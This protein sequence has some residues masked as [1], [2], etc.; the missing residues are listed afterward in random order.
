[1]HATV[2]VPSVAVLNAELNPV[3]ATVKD[4]KVT[5]QPV[6]VG[7][8]NGTRTQILSGLRRGQRVA[9]TNLQDLSNGSQ[10]SV[11]SGGT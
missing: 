9:I 10:V 5:F 11:S 7:A 8:S 1:V 3:V 2:S 6:Q 4:N